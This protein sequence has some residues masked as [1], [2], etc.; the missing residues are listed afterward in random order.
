M[1]DLIGSNYLYLVG[2]SMIAFTAALMLVSVL[3][4][5]RARHG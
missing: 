3:D 2:G 1:L 4:A 5:A